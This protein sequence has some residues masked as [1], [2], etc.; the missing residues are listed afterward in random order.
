MANIELSLTAIANANPA[1]RT[2]FANAAARTGD[3]T[4]Y[5]AA[6]VGILALQTDT[7]QLWYLSNHSPTTWTA[8][9][10]VNLATDAEITGVAAKSPLVGADTFLVEDSAASDAKKSATVADIRITESQVTDLTHTDATAIHDNVAAEI[11]AVAEKTVPI[12]A[13]LVLAE[14]SADSNNKKKVQLVNLYK[15]A[16]P[17]TAV[18]GATYTTDAGDVYLS[19]TRPS[20]GACAITLLTAASFTAGRLLIIKD[21]SGNAGTN[22]ITIDPDGSETIDGVATTVTIDIDYGGMV[23]M[24]NGTNW[25]KQPDNLIDVIVKNL[26]L[27][28]DATAAWQSISS[29]S[30][31]LTP[32]FANGINF[33]HTLTENTT[34]QI[35]DGCADGKPIQ[36]LVTQAATPYTFAVVA[37]YHLQGGPAWCLDFERG[38]QQYGTVASHAALNPTTAMT[39]DAWVLP[40]SAPTVHNEQHYLFGKSN[41]DA[42]EFQYSSI[43]Q[44]MLSGTKYIRFALRKDGSTFLSNRLPYTFSL[45]NW[46]HVAM[47]FDGSVGTIADRITFFINGVDQGHGTNGS[48]G[49]VDTI[50]VKTG[51]FF[52]SRVPQGTGSGTYWDGKMMAPRMHPTALSEAQIQAI[53]NEFVGTD[54]DAEWQTQDGAG[55]NLA[56]SAAAGNDITLVNTPAWVEDVPASHTG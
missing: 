31:T 27:Q 44:W 40:E 26:T 51:A 14:D 41:F 12:G 13:D 22:A 49:D 5:V 3:A 19:V 7:V 45:V 24:S 20:A 15:V 6:E 17:R 30:N 55:T 35:P 32:N 11:S 54:A 33:K 52:L 47:T 46:T 10:T 48:G 16:L 56:D 42:S 37:G 1:Y 23:L 36:V 53:M 29:S 9:N 2:T 25:V 50:W 34:L 43:G 28:G 8:F 4:S 21:E 38:S 18:A 39:F